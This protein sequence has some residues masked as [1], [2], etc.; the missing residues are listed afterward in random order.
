MRY[1][2]RTLLRAPGFTIVALLTLALG[3]GANTAI[4][5]FVNGVLLK[6]LPY[7]DPHSIVLVWEKTPDGYSNGI[8]TLNYLDWKHQNSVFQEMAAVRFGG[9]VTL[10][11]SGEPAQLTAGI[12]SAPYFDIFGVRPALGRTFASDEDQAG[13]S[14]VVILSH[15]LWQ[16][17][18]GADPGI[19]GRK[20][21]LNGKPTTVIGVLPAHGP[22]D[23]SYAQLWIPLEFQP[24]DMTR[25]YHWIMSF[26]RLKPGVTLEK[27]Q[28]QMD[29]I[30]ARIADA[31]PESNKGWGVRVERF[32]DQLVGRQL[33]RSL[34]VLLAAVGAILLIGCANLA[35]LTLA[36]GTARERE[37]AVRAALGAGRRRLIRQLLEENLVV[38]LVGGCL[39]LALG[40][41]MMRGL[42]IWLPT[43]YLPSEADI[44]I[45]LNILVFTL[46]VSILTAILFG[47]AP[48]FQA[49]RVDL[50]GSMREGGRSATSGSGRARL[51]SALIVSEVALAFIL[52]SGAGLLI[53][54]FYRLQQVDTGFDSNNVMT[55]GIPIAPAKFP[56]PVQLVG[57]LHEL[58]ERLRAVPGVRNVAFTNA[59]PMQG[60]GDGMPFLI[61]GREYVDMAHRTASF[62]K[63]VTPSYFETLG[64]HLLRGRMLKDQDRPGAPPVL[65]INE[66]MAK[67]NFK[68][69]DPIGKRI[70][71]QELL[72]GQPGLGQEI[73]WEVVGVVGDEQTGGLGN[74]MG[75]GV[76]VSY[77]QSPTNDV[78]MVLRSSADPALLT[79]SITAAVHDVDK[80]QALADLRSLDEIKSG[81]VSSDRMQ[82]LLL[83]TFA[84][85]A[86]LLAAVGIYGVISYS[87]TQRTQELGIRAAL[88]ASQWELLGL[89][90][91][92]GMTL[93][94][95]GLVVGIAGSLA[96]TQLLSTL[97]F[98]ISPRDPVTLVSVAAILGSVAFAACYIP[99]RRAAGIDPTV[100]LRYE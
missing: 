58:D 47:L 71:I 76:Y 23:R 88:G 13:K 14:Q 34:Y 63:R 31:F 32:E 46:L 83:A 78:Y 41:G 4:F 66:S 86:L 68:G 30:G 51:R 12:V 22:F 49:T 28:A 100:A 57:Y 97:L 79:N 48:A 21:T 93:A 53:G 85:L 64:I 11:G 99:A 18:F 62:Y 29:T 77:A 55:A 33:R 16:S 54:S 8:S 15:R 35:N 38:A 75:P 19:L 65:V 87:V 17:R 26:A 39:G 24:H 69:E 61:A 3:I 90:I 5:S 20:L 37:L 72:Y 56:Q 98:G 95:G 73:A 40:Y 44:G 92:Q 70:L 42:K 43:G 91:R 96:L 80:N 27:A 67:R 45:D 7:Q 50:A 81:S 6:P 52:L 2:T 59:L 36:R 94:I 9:A 25:D 60:G 82:T 89:V 84:T 1:A 74:R 10:T